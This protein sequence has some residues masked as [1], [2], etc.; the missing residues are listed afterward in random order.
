MFYI[1]ITFKYLCLKYK[2]TADKTV[3]RRT[4]RNRDFVTKSL[5]VATRKWAQSQIAPMITF[6]SKSVG[7]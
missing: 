1:Y 2:N 6:A 5:M 7:Q 4:M 3:K